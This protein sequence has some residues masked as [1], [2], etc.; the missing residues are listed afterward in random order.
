[1]ISVLTMMCHSQRMLPVFSTCCVEMITRWENSMLHEGSSEIDVWP[2]FQNLTGDVISRTA[3]GS[4]YQ[5]G[6][7][8]FQLQ[9]ELA[10]RL[11]QSF[12]TIFIPGYWFVLSPPTVAKLLF[13]RSK[14]HSWALVRHLH[15]PAKS[16]IC[17][18]YPY[19]ND[20]IRVPV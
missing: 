3:F 14:L 19:F 16:S 6:R 2:E 1:M 9:E 13:M 18:S 4:S 8:I 20:P 12:Q 5:E 17:Y 11:I 15:V 10:E 7:R